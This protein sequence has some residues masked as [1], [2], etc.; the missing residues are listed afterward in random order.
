MHL[1]T[2]FCRFEADVTVADGARIAV[3][4]PNAK[5]ARCMIVIN[6]AW[7]GHKGFWIFGVDSTLDG[8]APRR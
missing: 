2:K 1:E 6:L 7:A 3:V 8:M 5:A 4:G